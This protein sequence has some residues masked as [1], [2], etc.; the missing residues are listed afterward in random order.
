LILIRTHARFEEARSVVRAERPS[1]EL[2]EAPHVSLR[3]TSALHPTPSVFL[4]RFDLD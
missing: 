3:E 1:M 2:R 4:K